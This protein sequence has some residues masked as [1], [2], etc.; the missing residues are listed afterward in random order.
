[1]KIV[2]TLGTHLD[3]AAPKEEPWRSVRAIRGGAR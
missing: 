2:R 3:I 1:L